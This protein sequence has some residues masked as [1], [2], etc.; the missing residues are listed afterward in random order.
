MKP[1]AYTLIFILCM[2]LV[3]AENI[4]V[5]TTV[6]VDW[7]GN[8]TFYIKVE[9]EPLKDDGYDKRFNCSSQN[10]I[11]L[12]ANFVK[13]IN[14][15]YYN[16]T[17]DTKTILNASLNMSSLCYNL[18]RNYNCTQD[19]TDRIEAHTRT[20]VYYEDCKEERTYFESKAENVSSVQEKCESD[21]AN[22]ETSSNSLSQNYATCKTDL[23]TTKDKSKNDQ[24][25]MFILGI[26]GLLGGYFYREYRDKVKQPKV[27]R[28]QGYQGAQPPNTPKW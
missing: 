27:M 21:K 20:I 9:G 19:L 22:C 13:D 5:N 16:I 24:M 28:D 25:W 2:G 7:V 23:E 18:E 26:G 6:A 14:M 3:L 8:G 11:S 1:L 12:N 4:K 10:D 15:K 17:S